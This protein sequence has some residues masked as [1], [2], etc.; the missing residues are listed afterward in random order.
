MDPVHVVKR[1]WRSVLPRVGYMVLATLLLSEAA[2]Y[3]LLSFSFCIVPTPHDYRCRSD[4]GLISKPMARFKK[5]T[6]FEWTTGQARAV[7]VAASN[8]AYDNVFSINNA[9]YHSLRHY[10]PEKRDGVYR[11]VVLG[12]SMTNEIHQDPWPD[13]ANDLLG[14]P[15]EVYAFGVDGGGAVNWHHVFFND[16]VPQYE[17]DALVIAAFA[18]DLGRAYSVFHSTQDHLYFGR[19]A[20]APRSEEDFVDAYL[21]RMVPVADVVADEKLAEIVDRVAGRDHSFKPLR[22]D[23]YMTRYLSG[24][25]SRFRREMTSGNRA[26]SPPVASPRKDPLEKHSPA[27]LRMV[28]EIV[29]HCLAAGKPVVF[30]AIPDYNGLVAFLAEGRQSLIQ[31][32]VEALAERF[33]VTL[34]FDGF[35]LFRGIDPQAVREEY[36]L[37]YDHHWGQKA[38]DL[39]AD[40]FARFI[41]QRLPPS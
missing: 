22:W 2:V 38:S 26:A 6:G 29:E 28:G 35:E 4:F 20:K 16:V 31:R 39:Y 41:S 7:R 24:R 17:F 13:R 1:R 33:G 32:E 3:L 8:I 27:N 10:H 12:D 19:F 21:P 23:F 18:S 11:I 15:Y 34:L 36:W 25:I 37:R 14:K 5:E 40:G 9:G 30:S